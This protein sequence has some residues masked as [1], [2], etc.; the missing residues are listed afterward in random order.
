MKQLATVSVNQTKSFA[1]VEKS[2]TETIATANVQKKN[3]A[4]NHFNGTMKVV[5][6]SVT[7]LTLLARVAQDGMHRNANV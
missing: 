5:I 2:G 4:K 3:H 1:L 7:L 6:A